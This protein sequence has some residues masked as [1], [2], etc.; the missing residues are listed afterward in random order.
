[1]R[2][3]AAVEEAQPGHVQAEALDRF[4]GR[5]RPPGER[6]RLVGAD[7]RPVGQRLGEIVVALGE[8][9]FDEQAH[10]RRRHARHGDRAGRS[11]ARG[12]RSGHP[13]PLAAQGLSERGCR[14][15]RRVGGAR[16]RARAGAAAVDGQRGHRRHHAGGH[17]RCLARTAPWWE[18]RTRRRRTTRRTVSRPA[19]RRAAAVARASGSREAGRADPL[20]AAAA[21]AVVEASVASPSPTSTIRLDPGTD[22]TRVFSR[23]CGCSTVSAAAAV[24]SLSVEAGSEVRARPA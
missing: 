12:R 1:M 18:R 9:P 5:R 3:P 6:A 4:G 16:D 21:A 13:H 15:R 8:H 23:V 14:R 10:R 22:T 24:S 7:S 17:V 20:P 2:E 11:L 19:V